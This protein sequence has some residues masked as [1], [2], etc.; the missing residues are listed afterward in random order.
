YGSASDGK[1]PVCTRRGRGRRL[2]SETPPL[3]PTRPASP[4]V[5]NDAG[6]LRLL[7]RRRQQSAFALVRQSSRADLAQVV[8]AA[9]SSKRAPMRT[10]PRD[11]PGPPQL[12]PGRR[13][14]YGDTLYR[15]AHSTF[16]KE[17][18]DFAI[19]SSVIA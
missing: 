10:D 6:P 19:Q 9:R 1:A 5:L 14:E 2:V 4:L 18:E 17:T 8:V 7:W 12:H 16:V 3:V 11:T 15:T 13:G